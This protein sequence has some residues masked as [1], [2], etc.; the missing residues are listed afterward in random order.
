[1]L[2]AVVV[3]SGPNGLA[4]AITLAR[5]GLSVELW[6]ANET[7][8]G[9]C[10]SNDLVGMGC[11]HDLGAA[12]QPLALAS[13]FFRSLDL[14]SHGL[15]WAIPEV[16]VVHPL[17]GGRAGVG[18]RS[19][20]STAERL[21]VDSAAYLRLFR[22]LVKNSEGLLDFALRPQRSVPPAPLTSL[23]FAVRAPLPASWLAKRFNT[24]EARAIMAGHAA[25]AILPLSRPMTSSFAMLFAVTSHADGWPIPIGGAQAISNALAAAFR[26]FGG[27]VRLGQRVA[28]ID[29]L[30]KSRL[31]ILALTP[32]QIDDIA[33]HRLSSRYRR[34]LQRFRYGP[35]A[36]KVD[37]VLDGP[38]P[39]VSPDARQAA[40]VHVGGRFDEVALAERDVA[41]GR[42]PSRPFVLVSEPTL[43]D[44]TRSSDGKTVVW[45]YTHAPRGCD[46]DFSGRVDDQIERFAPG[47]KDLVVGRNVTM[48]RDLEASNANLVG[49]DVGGGSYGGLQLLF[50]PAI[51][52][53]PYTTSD[54][55]IF[56]GSA[57]TPPGAGV[58]GMAGMLAATAARNTLT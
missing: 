9:A 7:L 26:S 56:V 54:P 39:W 47:F 57:S 33:G 48:P 25:H 17:E 35:G 38:I 45:A 40:T 23:R 46:V 53:N 2:D 3:G 12:V 27:T 8:G 52:W 1:M 20:A 50:R 11:V 13:P 44:P 15:D 51:R 10:R 28:D 6:E 37:Y 49:G 58:H 16:S 5:E 21:G 29:A 30:P 18:Y 32:K 55:Q 22:P 43:F 31:T 24:A 42:I 34:A 19:L 41:R 14:A 4:A 36:L